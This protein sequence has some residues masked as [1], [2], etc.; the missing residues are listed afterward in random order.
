MTPSHRPLINGVYAGGR[1]SVACGLLSV[2]P[3]LPRAAGQQDVIRS[4]DTQQEEDDG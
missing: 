3:V 1:R 2:T 4:N